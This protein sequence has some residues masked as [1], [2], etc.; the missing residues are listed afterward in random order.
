MN[1]EKIRENLTNFLNKDK[2]KDLNIG[3]VALEYIIIALAKLNKSNKKTVVVCKDNLQIDTLSAFYKSLVG[4]DEKILSF[5]EYDIKPYDKNSPSSTITS[6]QAN[7]IRFLNKDSFTL[8]TTQ[9]AL[10]RY[11]IP[12]QNLESKT[13]S[14]QVNKTINQDDFIKQLIELGYE[15]QSL[16]VAT[17]TFAVRGYIIDVFPSGFNNPIRIE[18]FG[19]SIES[20]KTFSPYT[21]RT[22]Q[23]IETAEVSFCTSLVLDKTTTNSFTK[24]YYDE[25]GYEQEY[26]NSIYSS[27]VNGIKPKG[28]ENYL[29]LFQEKTYSLLEL[30]QEKDAFFIYTQGFEESLKDNLKDIE[31]NYKNRLGS[32]EINK[33][34]SFK[35]LKP[36]L[37]YLN[38]EQTLDLLSNLKKLKL[39]SFKLPENTNTVNASV[40]V[41]PSGLIEREQDLHNYLQNSSEG[42]R[43]FASC[44]SEDKA[45]TLSNYFTKKDY[46]V[47][48]TYEN[49]ED[50]DKNKENDK[51]TIFIT[52]LH[53][54]SG[55]SADDTVFLSEKELS[56]ISDF[57]VKSLRQSKTKASRN[58]I[59]DASM[60]SKGDLVVHVKHGIGKFE[61]LVHLK[62]DDDL[63]HDC[64]EILY[65]G[66]DKLFLP[67][68]N[69]DL[70]TR[71]GSKG[72]TRLDSLKGQSW[73][74]RKKQAQSK[75]QEIA[76]ELV[77]TAAKRSVTKTSSFHINEE[78]YEKFARDFKY[79]PTSD[80]IQAIEDIIND[81]HS[82]KNIDRLI[83]GDV[84]FG[85][86][87]VA[88]RAAFLIAIE[89]FQVCV[90]CPTT[91][92]AMQHYEVFKERLEKFGLK[93]KMLSRV[94]ST[95]ERKKV[96]E[97]LKNGDINVV[98]G[99]HALLADSVKF[100]NLKLA[101]I[102]EEQ[103]FGVKD[104]EKIKSIRNNLHVIS[105]SA[106]PIPRTLQMAMN[107]IKD[108]SLITTPPSNRQNVSSYVIP[109]DVLHIKEAINRE[110]SRK[111]QVFF[112][113]N[114]IRHMDEI[115]SFI[116]KH[117]ENPSYVKAHGQ[118]PI[119]ALEDNMLA[120]KK[121]DVDILIATNIVESGI[122]I[123]NANTMII[124]NADNFGLAQLYQLKGRIGRSATKGFA[125]MTYKADK[126]LNELAAK[127]LEVI[128]SLD[129]LGASFALAKHDLDIRGAGNLLGKEQSGYVKEIGIELYQ[130]FLE[131][132]IKTV[133]N[134]D[135]NQ[136]EAIKPS[137]EDMEDF[138]VKVDLG[139]PATIP[140][141]YVSDIDLRMSLYLKF[142]RLENE[143]DVYNFKYELI[144]RFGK[145]PDELENLF[146]SF[147]VKIKCRA[148]AVSRLQLSKKGFVIN[149]VESKVKNI[150]SLMGFVQD[151]RNFAKL[152]PDGSL[153]IAKNI[154][155]GKEI[156][157]TFTVLDNLSKLS[158]L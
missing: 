35:P 50:T 130:K 117:I 97:D 148:L 120:F 113:C 11:L 128:Q 38:Q 155:D 13:I 80:Q 37:L 36:D 131:Q 83:C 70:I 129:Y 24:K 65:E 32:Y 26:K 64:L 114:R 146:N 140:T 150:Q 5:P 61:N 91:L 8:F 2:D 71:Y 75:I 76:Y 154:E 119:K 10:I 12:S 82:S 59:Y 142:G 58:K 14:L 134:R 127:R 110:L 53:I 1:I 125:Y 3:S 16:V 102:D 19:D 105:M 15:R 40:K 137:Y 31:D 124:Y 72:D 52:R 139:I 88:L 151:V 153:F 67:I 22:I 100:K 29:V 78:M 68:E 145:L 147:V 121:G 115:E 132:A 138:V 57:G 94:V 152:R 111:G 33:S 44:T 27:I 106:T 95:A 4:S 79:I 55:F 143:E 86:T 6:K 89:K 93:V 41:I 103:S 43:I 63:V 96:K 149:F 107:S 104:K 7:A 74:K 156:E 54:G 39:T 42:K 81:L 28:Y 62:M 45:E 135:K 51:K 18:M 158:Y 85:K 116:N 108:L 99:T 47:V 73:D 141:D 98:V 48:N 133:Q 92:L 49:E 118:M 25:L 21:Q 66:G 17:G 109:F 20:I 122:D 69:I 46:F 23:E 101:I 144:D 84:G 157:A 34:A 9:S 136:E 90:I 60:L 30:M 87:E 112:I 126:K 56:V 77:L 123:S